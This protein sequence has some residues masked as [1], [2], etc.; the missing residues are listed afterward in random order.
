MKKTISLFVLFLVL[1]ALTSCDKERDVPERID[2]N[3]TAAQVLESVK[4]I[5]VNNQVLTFDKVENAVSYEVEIYKD[6]K[7]VVETIVGKNSLDL[8][9]YHLL[10][11]YTVKIKAV[12]GINSSEVVTQ[13]ISLLTPVEDVILEAEA[14]LL[15]YTLYKGNG[16]AHG[17]AY[18][19]DIDNC[20]QGVYYNVF[21]YVAGEYTLEAH[22]LTDVINSFHE[23]YVNGV[24]QTKFVYDET[25]GWGNASSINTKAEAV[26][27]TLNAGWNEI[28]IIK[29]GVSSNNYG[30]WA[31]LDYFVLKGKNYTY[32]PNQSIQENATYRLEAEMGCAIKQTQVSGGFRWYNNNRINVPM[33]C[34]KA[35]LGYLRGNFDVA[36]D[37]IEWQFTTKRAGKYEVKISYAS[38]SNNGACRIYFYNGTQNLRDTTVSASDLLNRYHEQIITLDLGNGWDNPKVNTK[39]FVLELSQGE[40][41]IYALRSADELGYFQLDY[42]ELVYIGE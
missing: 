38:D 30:G 12:K 5:S 8:T 27:L 24:Y 20:G 10:G 14:G 15:D 13:T 16:L 1:F 31:E 17:G 28:C 42:I 19:G 39:T 6:D 4:N 29:N 34:A 22:Y 11:T 7:L 36:N 3:P 40:N 2:Y 41:F 21:C 35:S 37:G 32:D 25:T 23:V 9:Q 33:P 18:I 26:I